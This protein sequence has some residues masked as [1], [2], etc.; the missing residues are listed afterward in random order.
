VI[1]HLLGKREALSSNPSTAKKKKRKKERNT[2]RIYIRA[3]DYVCLWG[4]GSGMMDF[5]FLI[6]KLGVFFVLFR[7]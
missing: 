2:G 6:Y 1:E 7:F 5:H 4:T 3:A